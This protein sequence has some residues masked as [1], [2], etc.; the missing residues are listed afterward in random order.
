M[1]YQLCATAQGTWCT[2]LLIC[3]FS[4]K[5]DV[6]YLPQGCGHCWITWRTQSWGGWTSHCQQLC[7][8]AEHTA[9][10]RCTSEHFYN[11]KPGLMHSVP[12]FPVQ[13][14]HLK[15]YKQHLSES[16]ESIVAV[17]AVHVHVWAGWVTAIGRVTLSWVY[18]GTIKTNVGLNIRS[19]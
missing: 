6:L 19:E 17:M 7:W 3:L 8:G 9:P 16:T 1:L 14:I 2:S 15:L 18:W 11:G 13:E 5:T 4:P 12:S 10:P